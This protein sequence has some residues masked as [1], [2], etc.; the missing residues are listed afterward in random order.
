MGTTRPGDKISNKVNEKQQETLFKIHER[1]E[2]YFWKTQRLSKLAHN[3]YMH[4]YSS[5]L[6][7]VV[8]WQTGRGSIPKKTLKCNHSMF[9]L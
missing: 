5:L 1:L 2:K 9:L 8:L 7:T 4:E 6:T 3:P